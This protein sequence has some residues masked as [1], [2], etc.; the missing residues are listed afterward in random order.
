MQAIKQILTST[1]LFALCAP[2]AMAE[3]EYEPFV[4]II[5]MGGVVAVDTGNTSLHIR[6][7]QTDLETD[8]LKNNE[9]W[10]GW[11]AQLGVGYV[12]ELTN[13]FDTDDFQFL[14]TINPQFNVYYIGDHDIDGNVV[15]FGD[16]YDGVDY[17]QEFSST[18]LMFDLGI[19][20]VQYEE[21]SLYGLA[22]LGIAFNTLNTTFSSDEF[23]FYN[24]SNLSE[25]STSF[26]YEFGAG[27]AYAIDTDLTVNV[28]YLITGINDVD[29][30]SNDTNSKGFDVSAD[31]YNII[32]QAGMIGLRYAL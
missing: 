27:L 28:Q 31:Q 18:R 16:T 30:G 13:D 22:G 1:T 11:V 32:T 19:T 25:S 12:Y 8:L 5:A 29:L 20:L 17:T 26:A 10:S 6:D 9:E 3:E 7:S 24:D 2:I 14:P 4:E 21:I 15:R 23:P